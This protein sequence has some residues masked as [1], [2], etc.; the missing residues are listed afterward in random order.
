M[1]MIGWELIQ[2][3]NIICI[4]SRK[5]NYFSS[6]STIID[7]NEKCSV[8]RTKSARCS[9]VLVVSVLVISRTV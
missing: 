2:N 1:K 9:R 3:N 4:F 6:T 5:S 7:V 8:L